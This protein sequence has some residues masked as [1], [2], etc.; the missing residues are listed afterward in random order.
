M[1]PHWLRT[2]RPKREPYKWV[3]RRPI[4]SV[5]PKR[6]VGTPGGE[7]DFT[8]A[9]K[10]YSL[11]GRMIVDPTSPDGKRWVATPGSAKI[12][13]QIVCEMAGECCELEI[14][15]N[16]WKRA[17]LQCGHRYHGK[18]K[19]MGGAFTDDRIWINGKKMLFWS[20]PSC[21]TEHHGTP[22]WSRRAA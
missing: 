7:Y 1:I 19:K 3:R 20:C 18:H 16:C 11:P 4:R 8:Y 12:I 6:N 5:S 2:T 17:P 14:K 9:G 10:F 13:R 22:Q 15:S 21:H